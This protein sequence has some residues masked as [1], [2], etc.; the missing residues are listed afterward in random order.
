MNSLRSYISIDFLTHQ[1]TQVIT[2]LISPVKGLRSRIVIVF[3]FV[4]SFTSFSDAQEMYLG[5]RLGYG[6][7]NIQAEGTSSHKLSNRIAPNIAL[8]S[9]IRFRGSAFGVSFEPGYSLKGVRIENDDLD[10]R[11]NY[12]NLPLLI[13][14][15]P[16]QK[17]RLSIGPELS[18]LTGANNKLR[19]GKKESIG[20]IYTEKSEIAG[21]LGASYALD[22]FAEVGARYN[23]SFNRVSDLDVVLNQTDISNSYFQFYLLFKIIN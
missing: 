10:Y 11:F 19:D 17:I 23:Y 14:Y 22:F 12:L 3:L 1:N 18:Y 15:Y 13:D 8:V 5:L 2:T 21:V 6:F 9:N 7:S 4:F 20:H 16:S